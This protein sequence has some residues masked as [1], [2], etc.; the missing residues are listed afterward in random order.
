M[1]FLLSTFFTLDFVSKLYQDFLHQTPALGHSLPSVKSVPPLDTT[2]LKPRQHSAKSGQTG[3][4]LI[5]SAELDSVDAGVSGSGFELLENF[6]VFELEN[7]ELSKLDLD[8]R[9]VFDDFFED[10]R[11]E[12]GLVEGNVQGTM[13]DLGP[14][15]MIN[16]GFKEFYHKLH[17][18]IFQMTIFFMRI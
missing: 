18:S 12:D 13:G 16:V 2:S 6:T 4:G 1:S 5:H 11:N 3:Q 8:V 10:L 7:L 15:H 9:Q 17:V 14:N